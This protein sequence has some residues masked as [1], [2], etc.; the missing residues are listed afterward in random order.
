MGKGK[1]KVVGIAIKGS[2]KE[3]AVLRSDYDPEKGPHL[4]VNVGK[5]RNNEKYAFTYPGDEEHHSQICE[6]LSRPDNKNGPQTFNTLKNFTEE[7][8]NKKVNKSDSSI[9][10]DSVK[11]KKK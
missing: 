7:Q 1:D 5:G 3:T 8:F 4:N 10:K 9:T 2:N 6:R 11:K